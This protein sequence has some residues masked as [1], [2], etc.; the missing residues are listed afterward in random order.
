MVALKAIH[1]RASDNDNIQY[2][3]SYDLND[4]SMTYTI[5]EHAQ[6]YKN[7]TMVSGSSRNKIDACNRDIEKATAW[8]IVVLLSDDMICQVDGWDEILRKEFSKT[9]D[10]C[11]HHSDGYAG[12][13][14]QTMVIFGRQYFDRFGYLYHPEY[15]SLFA[16]NRQQDVAKILKKY[17]YYP[18]VLFRHEHYANNPKIFKDRQYTYTER[19]YLIDQRTYQR[20]K[21]ANFGL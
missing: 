17:K 9:L 21:A 1:T 16:D 5:R 10:L 6:T 13:R 20:H 15:I 4:V 14:L 19:F 2:L 18:R 12:D 11:V 8:D 3:V 7:V